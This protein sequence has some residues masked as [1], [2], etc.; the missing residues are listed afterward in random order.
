MK[1]QTQNRHLPIPQLLRLRLCTV[2]TDGGIEA[3]MHQ[4]EFPYF[5]FWADSGCSLAFL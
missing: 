2:Y 3:Q 1:A 4:A 5:I